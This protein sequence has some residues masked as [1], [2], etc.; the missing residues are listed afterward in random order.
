MLNGKLA[1]HDIQDVEAFTAT[2]LQRNRRT[3]AT[4]DH[5][6]I[7]AWLIETCWELSLIYRPDNATVRFSTYARTTL[8]YRLTD[9]IRTR[10]GRTRWQFKDRTYERPR[11]TLISL[12][13]PELEHA[14]QRRTMD[15][16]ERSDPSFVRALYSRTSR[17]PQDHHSHHQPLDAAA[18]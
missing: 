1:L 9:Y 12:D 8:T 18:A 2:I 6:D 4:E 13:D 14:H 3:T 7:H 17:P 11:P 5:E 16:P 10:N 15:P